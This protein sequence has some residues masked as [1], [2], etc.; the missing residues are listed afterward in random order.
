MKQG[1]AEFLLQGFHGSRVVTMQHWLT[2]TEFTDII[3]IAEMTPGPLGINIASFVGT[4]TAG[5][6]GT[7]IATLSYVFPAMVIVILLAILY[8]KYRSLRYVKGGF[9]RLAFGSSS[10]GT[11]GHSFPGFSVPAAK[12]KT[13]TNPDN[14]RQWSCRSSYLWITGIGCV[15]SRSFFFA[16]KM[17]WN[18]PK[19]YAIM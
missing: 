16:G 8:D 6:P 11:C 12:E 4:R 13:W 19:K 2:D 9:K 14:F 15:N 18:T 1:D 5:I 17:L 10:Y 7:L 3:S